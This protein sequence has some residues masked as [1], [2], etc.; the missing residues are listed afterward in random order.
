LGGFREGLR[1]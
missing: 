1:L